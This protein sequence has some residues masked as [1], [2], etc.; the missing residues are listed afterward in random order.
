MLGVVWNMFLQSFRG[1][2]NLV[3][4][5]NGPSKLDVCARTCMLC[6]TCVCTNI[7]FVFHGS[8]RPGPWPRPWAKPGLGPWCFFFFVCFVCTQLGIDPVVISEFYPWRWWL[9]S[10]VDYSMQSKRGEDQLLNPHEPARHV[11]TR[12]YRKAGVDYSK[13]PLQLQTTSTVW[14]NNL[15]ST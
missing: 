7:Y 10:A 12:W 6:W 2:R 5:V 14:L 9:F 3:W 11:R 15:T 1:E 13:R 8:G 4:G